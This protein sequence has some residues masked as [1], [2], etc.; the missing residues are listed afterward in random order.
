VSKKTTLN[1]KTQMDSKQDNGKNYTN[2]NQE[3]TIMT[4]IIY[5]KLD[6]RTKNIGRELLNN[7]KGI[8]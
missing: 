8:N 7:D 2:T 5:Y 1:A 4:I 6:F 3:K